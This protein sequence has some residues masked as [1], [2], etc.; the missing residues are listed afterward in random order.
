V[1]IGHP[2]VTVCRLRACNGFLILYIQGRCNPLVKKPVPR[3]QSFRAI[4]IVP[5]SATATRILHGR[6]GF[7]TLDGQPLYEWTGPAAM[8]DQ[9]KGWADAAKPGTLAL[10]TQSNSWA[11]SEVKV[12]RLDGK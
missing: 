4:G 2:S 3:P 11:V 9:R 8:L 1:E 6:S 12:K 7:T 5:S 10:G